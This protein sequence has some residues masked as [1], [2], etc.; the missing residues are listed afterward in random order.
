MTK[1]FPGGGPQ[2]DGEDPHFP[3][4]REQAYPAGRFEEHLEPFRAAIDAGTAA[5]MP[6]YGMPVGLVRKGKAIE[7]VGFA[8]NKQIITDLLRDEL[9]YDGVVC[10]DWQFVRD[11][12][13]AGPLLPAKAWASSTST[14]PVE[15]RSSTPAAISSAARAAPTSC[16]NWSRPA[17]S[18]RRVSTSRSLASSPSPSSSACSRIR[19]SS[20]RGRLPPR[21]RRRHRQGDRRAGRLTGG[22][23]GATRRS[24]SG[25]SS[26]Q[27]RGCRGRSRSNAEIPG[28]GGARP[29]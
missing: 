6:Y 14:P 17:G 9:G 28:P 19:T 2:R 26:T 10:T 25:C 27:V 23:R 4:G 24:A 21:H 18:P 16:L 20:D 12:Q 8:F 7:E 3:Y 13:R 11:H 22:A 29:P 5:L 1:H 15:S